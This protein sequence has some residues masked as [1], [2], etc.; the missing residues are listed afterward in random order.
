MDGSA[1][2]KGSW[3]AA[4]IDSLAPQEGD[5]LIEGKR[6]LDTFASTHAT[7]RRRARERDQL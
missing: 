1:F 2:V 6:G 5:I 4:I 3:G 7:S